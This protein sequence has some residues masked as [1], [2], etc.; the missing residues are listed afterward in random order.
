LAAGEVREVKPTKEEVEARAK[1]LLAVH[2]EL[3]EESR[4][5]VNYGLD[6]LVHDPARFR[7]YVQSIDDFRG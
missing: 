4:A 1:I 5:V 3:S 6:L 2:R 7:T